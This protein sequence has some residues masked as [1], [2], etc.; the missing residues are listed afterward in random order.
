M[1]RYLAPR[2]QTQQMRNLWKRLVHLRRSWFRVAPPRC[3]SCS[4][5][6][7]DGEIRC[8]DEEQCELD[9][10]NRLAGA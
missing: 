8:R 7:L 9:T 1:P 2:D 5:P 6:L 3:P 10:Y 4:V